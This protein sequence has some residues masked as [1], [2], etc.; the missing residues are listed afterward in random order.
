MRDPAALKNHRPGD[1]VALIN[2]R[3]HACEEWK[4]IAQLDLRNV[5]R[6]EPVEIAPVLSSQLEPALKMPLTVRFIRSLHSTREF[7]TAVEQLPADDRRA[8]IML[9][10]PDPGPEMLSVPLGVGNIIAVCQKNVIEVLPSISLHRPA[11]IAIK[12]LLGASIRLA[13]YAT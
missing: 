9:M 11:G 3:L 5:A 13:H 8:R 2:A 4:S 1:G 10:N 7:G 6:R 12:D